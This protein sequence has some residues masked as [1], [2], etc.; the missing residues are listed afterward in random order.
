MFRVARDPFRELIWIES[1]GIVLAAAIDAY[2]LWKARF[3]AML[4]PDPYAIFIALFV[5]AT[6]AVLYVP[7]ERNRRFVAIGLA[8]VLIAAMAFFRPY[9]IA[10]I[11]LATVLAARLTFGFGIPGTAVG[12]LTACAAIALRV[13]S[14]TRAV[15]VPMSFP[16]VAYI[17]VFAGLMG[18]AFGL[19]AVYARFAVK[20]S[21]LAASEERERIAF[22]LHDALG[23]NLTTLNVQLENARR[24]RAIDPAKA[25]DYLERAASSARLLLSEV[26]EAVGVLSDEGRRQ[27]PSLRDVVD[28]LLSDFA[29]NHEVRFEERIDVSFEP[30]ERVGI[31]LYRV[32]QEALTN[33]ARHAGAT[34]LGVTLTAGA[35][36]ITFTISDNG[37]GFDTA[38][39]SGHGIASMRRRIEALGGRLEVQSARGQGT[40]VEGRV[41]LGPA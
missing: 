16:L 19:I 9:G 37:A 14:Q 36:E 3:G 33:V 8:A 13:W 26:R 10:P 1:A 39:A 22:D 2:L 35:R 17:A 25:D 32:L 28:G 6:A 34:V 24:Y 23:H 41:P 38:S 4:D 5:C 12:W 27:A 18:V 11:V 15:M 20:R 21:A 40:T 7:H 31:E 30:P 29:A